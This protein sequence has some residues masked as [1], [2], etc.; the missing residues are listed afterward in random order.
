MATTSVSVSALYTGRK[1]MPMHKKKKKKKGSRRG[2]S[3][4]G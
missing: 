4:R 1:A 3:R 2:G